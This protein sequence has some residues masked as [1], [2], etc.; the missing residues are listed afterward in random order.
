[1]VRLITPPPEL[2]SNAPTI[3]L[4]GF[5]FIPVANDTDTLVWISPEGESMPIH[6]DELGKIISKAF[7]A[8]F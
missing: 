1:M 5:K 8:H 6:P 3:H 4:A 7:Y 2:A